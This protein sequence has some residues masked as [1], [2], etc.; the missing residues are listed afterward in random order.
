MEEEAPTLVT[1]VLVLN[2]RVMSSTAIVSMLSEVI[3]AKHPVTETHEPEER[4]GVF[5]HRFWFVKEQL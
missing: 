5:A 3:E 4:F 2:P 1:S